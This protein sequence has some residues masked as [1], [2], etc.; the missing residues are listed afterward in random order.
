MG[1]RNLGLRTARAFFALDPSLFSEI[2][3]NCCCES[4]RTD[5]EIESIER[6]TIVRADGSAARGS[7]LLGASTL[8]LT[9]R[10]AARR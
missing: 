10:H 1:W 8:A 4:V 9:G 3:C 7:A 6:W 5:F 2:S